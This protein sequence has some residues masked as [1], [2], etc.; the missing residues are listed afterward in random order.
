MLMGVLKNNIGISL[1]DSHTQIM[2]SE[3][4]SRRQRG[5]FAFG[6][7][8]H[9]GTW[10][11]ISQGLSLKVLRWRFPLAVM[12]VTPGW[13]L[14]FHSLPANCTH[15]VTRKLSLWHPWFS[16]VSFIIFS[17]QA[18]CQQQGSL[19]YFV[20]FLM[21]WLTWIWAPGPGPPI[22]IQSCSLVSDWFGKKYGVW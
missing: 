5:K 14:L 3:Q 18:F 6:F 22:K 11:L 9:L 13:L 21:K 8:H 20:L 7:G 15:P 1:K 10:G 2:E 19:F 4:S 17:Q 16:F 12:S